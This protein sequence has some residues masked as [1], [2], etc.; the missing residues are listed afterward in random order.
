MR[1]TVTMAAMLTVIHLTRLHVL[2]VVLG[3]AVFCQVNLVLGLMK[4]M[5]IRF[6]RN[7]LQ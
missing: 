2:M 3:E 6:Q 5:N 7:R 1:A 4:L